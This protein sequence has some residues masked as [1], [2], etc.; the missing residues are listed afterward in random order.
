M[1][2]SIKKFLG[3]FSRNED[4]QM[5]L[6]FAIMTPLVFT[7]F[8]TSVELGIYK[9]RHQFLDRGLDM[10]VRNVRLNTGTEYTHADIK[11]MTCDFAGFLDDCETQLKLEMRPVDPRNFTEFAENEDC[12]D[13]SEP[14][15][16]SRTFVLGGQ[17]ELMLLRACYKFDPVF[18][19]SGLG[20][21]FATNGD[22]A[23]MARIV[24]IA[25][26]VQEP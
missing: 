19:T 7:A 16:P 23:G 13:A 1:I 5:L 12:T 11:S 15:N 10:A 6:E 17:N 9:M 8:L 22:N 24:S 26:F 21:D 20:Y 18:P 4:G 2:N 3:R 25:A 14:V